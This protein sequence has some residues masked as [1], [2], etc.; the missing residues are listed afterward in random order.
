MRIV[1]GTRP[2][3]GRREG[4]QPAK[5]PYGYPTTL[6]TVCTHMPYLDMM[7]KAGVLWE[8]CLGGGKGALEMFGKTCMSKVGDP[9]VHKM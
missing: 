3:I 8:R 9:V 1:P 6:S 7:P 4:N 2:S 5:T